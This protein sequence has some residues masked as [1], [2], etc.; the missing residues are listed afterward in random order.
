[1]MRKGKILLIIVSFFVARGN[2][3]NI[4]LDFFGGIAN[5]KG[6]LQ[7]NAKGGKQ[8]SFKQPNFAAGIGFQYEIS[9]RL[10]ARLA[11]KM[12]KIGAD[13]KKQPGQHQRNLNFYSSIFDLMLAAEYCIV[14]PDEHKLIPYAFAGIAMFHF[15]PYTEVTPGQKTFLQ[16]LSTEG[17]GFVSGRLPYKLTQLALPFGGGVKYVISDNVRIGLELSLRKTFTDYLDDVSTTYVD[18]N[19]L[20][21]NRGQTAVDLAY[22]GD[23]VGAGSYPPAGTQRGSL[24]AK[25]WYYFTGFTLSFR[26]GNGDGGGRGRRKSK[27]GCPVNR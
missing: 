2:G 17:E 11:V 27:T 25:D 1:M 23:E 10:Y 13:D 4:H 6:D 16:P 18:Q 22:R 3:Q 21:T 12:G 14:D 8:I 24:D 7:Y 26:L 19:L 20:L 15:N 5:Y 9:S